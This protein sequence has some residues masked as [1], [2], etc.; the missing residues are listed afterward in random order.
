M[1]LITAS[2]E[3]NSR[4][5]VVMCLGG[6]ELFIRLTDLEPWSGV[7]EDCGF[8]GSYKSFTV[9]ERLSPTAGKTRPCSFGCETIFRGTDLA[10]LA[11]KSCAR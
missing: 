7:V 9:D 8:G 3:G 5:A 10:Q 2:L 4:F 1:H 6:N 11:F